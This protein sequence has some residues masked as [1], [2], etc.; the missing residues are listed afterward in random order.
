MKEIVNHSNKIGI[1][2]VL[3]AVLSFTLNDTLIKSFSSTY[4]LHELVFIRAIIGISVLLLIIMPFSGGIS[5]LK[6]KRIGI[7]FARCVCVVI[8]NS[9]LFLSFSLMPFAEAIAIFFIAPMLTTILSAVFLRE[10]V[11]KWRWSAVVIGQIGVL[12]VMR[13]GSD[14]FQLASLFPVI[15]AMGYAS[16]NLLTRYAGRTESTF[17]LTFYIYFS[18]VIVGGLM[19]LYFGDGH[20]V[21][22]AG[23]LFE[24]V[25]RPWIM[26]PVEDVFWLILLGLLALSGGFFMAHGYRISNPAIVAPME[27][28]A[29]PL[30]MLWGYI[31]FDEWPDHIALL[32]MSFIVCSG[33]IT[34]WRERI[35]QKPKTPSSSRYRR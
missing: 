26:P 24:F 23:E 11:G 19:G 21:P 20:F 28:I 18:Y 34:I 2:S 1:L 15:A 13:P 35:H 31:F 3:F 4:A 33:L 30:T 10:K 14:V 6:T 17:T 9:F 16:L 12:T 5:I 8:A 29:L 7:H 22:I 32:G 27:Y 25:F